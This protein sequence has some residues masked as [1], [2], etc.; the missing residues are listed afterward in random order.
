MTSTDL[1]RAE[2]VIRAAAKQKCDPSPPR[3]VGWAARRVHPYTNGYQL[4]LNPPVTALS[5]WRSPT[6]VSDAAEPGQP[7]G[8]VVGYPGADHPLVPVARAAA[9]LKGSPPAAK[10]SVMAVEVG[11][12]S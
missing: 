9:T 12:H 7:F 11:L 10:A 3:G 8:G 1:Q 2:A 6:V 4:Y 5:R